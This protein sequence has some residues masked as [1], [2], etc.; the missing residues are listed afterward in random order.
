MCKQLNGQ[1]LK[2]LKPKWSGS[3]SEK[4][5]D[6][7]GPGTNFEFFFWPHGSALKFLPLLRAWTGTR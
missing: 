2:S 7:A 1:V 6:W 5:I 3:K 4:K